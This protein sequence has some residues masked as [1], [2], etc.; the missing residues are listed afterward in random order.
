[1][2]AKVIHIDNLPEYIEKNPESTSYSGLYEEGLGPGVFLC[3]MK[4]DRSP[5][6]PQDWYL[7][8]NTESGVVELEIPITDE[9][10]YWE[11]KRKA[12]EI[13]S[14]PDYS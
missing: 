8:D 4:L 12:E 9:E 14:Q 10:W 13:G 7:I 5:E 1:M 6:F 2:K 11:L 3:P